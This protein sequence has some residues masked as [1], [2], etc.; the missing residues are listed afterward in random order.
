VFALKEAVGAEEIHRREA[1]FARRALASWG[2]NPNLRILGNPELERLAIV[3]LGVRHPCGMLHANFVVALLSDLFG[4]QVR[5][6]CFCAGPYLHRVYPI[7][8]E[9]SAAMHA[10]AVRG[11]DGAKLA[12]TR[13]SFNYFISEAVFDYTVEAV[14]L[15]A[16]EGWKLLPLYR[17]DERTGLWQHATAPRRLPTL[18]DVMSGDAIPTA[19]ESALAGQLAEARRIL[20]AADGATPA[21]PASEPHDRFRWFPVPGEASRRSRFQRP[22]PAQ[23]RGGIAG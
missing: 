8:P 10:D 21:P 7:D 9:W 14:H 5:S 23:E 11:R 17:F 13:V 12:F 15:V 3:S 1:A 19:P 16:N 6:G 4:I 2:A 22:V 20:G 18:A